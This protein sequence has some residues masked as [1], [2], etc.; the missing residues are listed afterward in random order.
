M[1]VHCDWKRQE[2]AHNRCI[3]EKL[4]H[5]K[6]GSN[7]CHFKTNSSLH[8]LIKGLRMPRSISA[9]AKRISEVFIVGLV[10]LC[11]LKVTNRQEIL[12]VENYLPHKKQKEG[13]TARSTVAGATILPRLPHLCWKYVLKG[14]LPW[15][16]IFSWT[17]VFMKSSF[18]AQQ[19]VSKGCRQKHFPRIVQHYIHKMTA[20]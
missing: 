11:F 1:E 12:K 17:D 15:K 20:R 10:G 13:H 14:I 4:E 18:W 19:N 6:T 2:K 9:W 7:T 5:F 3:K 8:H 16:V